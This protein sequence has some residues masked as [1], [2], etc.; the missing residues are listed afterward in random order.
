ML[1]PFLLLAGCAAGS[2]FSP[3]PALRQAHIEPFA[4]SL[5]RTL[6]DQPTA[7][8]RVPRVR[9]PPRV[10]GPLC[11]VSPPV[12]VD[13][14]AGLVGWGLIFTYQMLANRFSAAWGSQNAVARSVWARYILEKGDYILGV[15]TLRNSLTAASFFATA[16]FSSL[17]L[18]IGTASQAASLSPLAR[19]KY[20]ST[21]LLLIMAAL[22][23]LQ[24][25]RY[26]NT[27]AFL[28]Q[29]AND[30][31]DETCSRGTVMLLMVLSQNCWAAG[32]KALYLLVPS[33]VWLVAGGP[34][35][36]AVS[37][38][39]LPILYYKDLP[40]PTNLLQPDEPTLRPYGYMLS[41]PFR[42]FDFFGFGQAL[43]VAQQTVAQSGEY[44][45]A[46]YGLV[47]AVWPPPREELGP[48]ERRDLSGL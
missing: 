31:R 11:L 41:G 40:A 39:M 22:L 2:A 24:C 28:F 20:A 3:P 21:S 46:K 4:R 33:L 14:L 23:Y 1:R 42:V 16:C 25:V 17:S 43:A 8:P 9:H 32:E 19:F 29:V 36:L 34:A 44:A 5:P 6:T 10:P 15:Q 18:L 7:S 37:A 12:T 48:G 30:E 35:M 38:A 26:M 27:C 13:L 47:G 45:Q